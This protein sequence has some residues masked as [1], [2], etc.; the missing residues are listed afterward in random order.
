MPV[1]GTSTRKHCHH[2]GFLSLF[3]LLP[4]PKHLLSPN[5]YHAPSIPP[6]RRRGEERS[7]ELN[8]DQGL[9]CKAWSYEEMA[10][11]RGPI[12]AFLEEAED[13]NLGA[14]W[15]KEG[16]EMGCAERADVG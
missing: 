1:P 8:Q 12:P 11:F 14:A 10:G 6:R 7:E 9:F 5:I 3:P 15:R 13:Q 4:S 16:A 2:T